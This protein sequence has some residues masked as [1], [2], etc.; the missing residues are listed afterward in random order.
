MFGTLLVPL[1]LQLLVY[2]TKRHLSILRHGEVEGVTSGNMLSATLLPLIRCH[3]RKVTLG[4]LTKQ[5]NESQTSYLEWYTRSWQQSRTLNQSLYTKENHTQ[6][7]S[8][9]LKQRACWAR[10]CS[11]QTHTAFCHTAVPQIQPDCR[12]N[13]LTDADRL[14]FFFLNTITHLVAHCL[15]LLSRTLLLNVTNA[16]YINYK[17]VWHQVHWS[18]PNINLKEMEHDSWP[19]LNERK[20]VGCHQIREFMEIRAS[21]PNSNGNMIGWGTKLFF[22][23][24]I[25]NSAETE[26]FWSVFQERYTYIKFI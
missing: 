20:L 3:P 21:L 17:K 10:V 25:T 14:S 24:N 19:K 16:D 9:R 22:L 1:L 5:K 15:L 7:T 11:P 6:I 26:W 8:T 2:F 4:M 23:F 12:F 13:T 18:K